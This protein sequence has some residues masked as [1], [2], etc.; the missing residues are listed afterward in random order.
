MGF[1]TYDLWGKPTALA[2]LRRLK[3]ATAERLLA[4]LVDRARLYNEDVSRLLTIQRIRVFG[5]F[6]TNSP[7]L[8]DIDISVDF[9]RKLGWSAKAV[10]AQAAAEAPDYVQ[11][12]YL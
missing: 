3:R 4:E 2:R 10:I 7:T 9:H 6:L 8:G 5:S 11:L 12:S 1:Q